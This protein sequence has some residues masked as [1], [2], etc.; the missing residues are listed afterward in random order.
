MQA[1]LA[2]GRQVV[3]LDDLS[4]GD[5]DR[6][7]AQV[8]LVQAS[9]TDEAAVR[10]LL[11]EYA[12]TGVIHLAGRKSAAESLAQPLAYYRQN[13]GGTRALITAMA[14]M[15]IHQLVLSSSASVYGS[16]EE[17]LISEDA[18]A[19]PLNPYGATKLAAEW[20]V[21]EAT[22]VHGL[23]HL[24]L[25]Y[26][27]VAGASANGAPCRS[28]VG[29]LRCAVDAVT[30]GARPVVFGRNYPTPDGSCVRDFVHVL[31]VAAVHAIAVDAL[32]AGCT[33][34]VYNVG[35]GVGFSVG[36]VLDRIRQVTGIDFDEE[37]RSRRDGDPVRVVASIEKIYR[38]LGWRPRY[39]LTDMIRSQWE[40]SRTERPL[41]SAGRS[42]YRLRPPRREAI[43]DQAA[44]HGAD[45][46]TPAT[47]ID[48]PMARIV[49]ISASVGAGHE[50][51]ARE[52]VARLA[53]R[54]FQVDNV[55]LL[56]VLPRW[57]ATLLRDVYHGILSWQPWIYDVLFR[58]ARTYKH[59]APITRTLLR[60]TRRRLL[61]QLPPDTR[62]VVAT[63]PLAAQIV[64]PLR[65]SGQLTVPAATYLT[66]FAVHPIWVA[67]GI[68]VHCAGHEM[69][70]AQAQELGANDV[71]LAGRLVSPSFRQPSESTKCQARE[72]F[73][74]PSTGRLALLVAGSWGVGEVEATTAEVAATGAVIPVVVCETNVGL[75]RR[76]RDQ[77][78]TNVFGWVDDMPSLLQAVDVLVENAGGLTAM[79][80]MACGVPVA[81]YRPIAGHG[82]A[83]AATMAQAGVARWVRTRQA[84]GPTLVE[85]AD[86]GSGLDQC[87]AALALFEA[88]PATVV[89]DLAKRGLVERIDD[90]LEGPAG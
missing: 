8:P 77:G 71:R 38:D 70:R 1:L 10:R 90:R 36:Q 29:L 74:L 41:W 80:A 60:P 20:I 35:C 21:G 34:G 15:G 45:H 75:Y 81:T 7:P 67:P 78:V 6:V 48:E 12:V 79:E 85:L 24:V 22:R 11:H 59:A 43:G 17:D 44:P 72:R 49:V 32:E 40:L 13:V 62:A 18:A 37:T 56:S 61:R 25:R 42:G 5:P 31:D 14:D 65:R 68:D 89:A 4:A 9:V 64:G 63:F 51:A 27:N 55:D 47:R 58:L 50:G 84:L 19:H 82:T 3:V 30:R 53:Q 46:P 28:D 16:P 26:F 66:D 88:D 52:L 23:R 33:G 73:G 86:G 69:S 39:G 57:V 87:Q 54:G 76:L 2:G 83:N